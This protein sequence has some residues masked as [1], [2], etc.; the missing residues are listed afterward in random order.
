MNKYGK[1]FEEIIKGE[2]LNRYFEKEKFELWNRTYNV[3]KFLPNQELI[4][5]EKKISKEKSKYT[6]NK[7]QAGKSRTKN[8]KINK[9]FTGGMA[10]LAAILYFKNYLGYYYSIKRFDFE[11]ENFRYNNKEYDVKILRGNQEFLVESRSST[12]KYDVCIKAAFKKFDV[13]GP[14]TNDIKTKEKINDLYLRPIYSYNNNDKLEKFKKDRSRLSEDYFNGDVDLY[15]VC[16]ATIEE[17]KNDKINVRKTMGQGK[18]EYL[19]VP[20][21]N[22]GDMVDF[23][24][25][26]KDKVCN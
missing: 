26:L 25:K 9:Q 4:E 22:A 8:Q 7:N 11:R 23:N 12:N 1:E 15:F 6:N 20:H 14:Y 21:R 19:C 24:K 3:L 2:Y 17:M 13:L 18:T 16:G 5:L 10:E